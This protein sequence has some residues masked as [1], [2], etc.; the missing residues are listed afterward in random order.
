MNPYETVVEQPLSAEEKEAL[1][2]RGVKINVKPEVYKLLDQRFRGVIGVTEFR[3]RMRKLGWTPRWA[4]ILYGKFTRDNVKPYKPKKKF[5]RISRVKEWIWEEKVKYKG[6]TGKWLEL[7]VSLY[8][9]NP[10]EYPNEELEDELNRVERLLSREYFTFPSG[11][12]KSRKNYYTREGW[13][14]EEVAEEEVEW[15]L[16]TYHYHM[17]LWDDTGAIKRKL[18]H[19]RIMEL[20]RRLR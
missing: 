6:G 4:L 17:I 7:R 2:T 15:G 13:E 8:T 12:K 10:T 18:E 14:R 9:Q 3:T 1:T 11:F 20:L 19:S 16:D 5:Y